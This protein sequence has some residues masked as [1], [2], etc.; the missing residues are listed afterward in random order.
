MLV[1]VTVQDPEKVKIHH[2][3]T[4]FGR[5]EGVINVD[6]AEDGTIIGV[7]FLAALRVTSEEVD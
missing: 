1:Y 7:E 2:T 4:F 5:S 3:E 6:C